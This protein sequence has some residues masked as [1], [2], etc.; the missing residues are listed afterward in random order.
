MVV[1]VSPNAVRNSELYK[2][3]KDGV[4]KPGQAC[5]AKLPSGNEVKVIYIKDDGVLKAAEKNAQFGKYGMHYDPE[6]E[7]YLDKSI[8]NSKGNLII[9]RHNIVDGKSQLKE[10]VEYCPR[11]KVSQVYCK[12]GSK[13]GHVWTDGRHDI[14]WGFDGLVSTPESVAT[15][16]HRPPYRNE[17]SV[18]AF[19]AARDYIRGV[20]SLDAYKEAM[21][22]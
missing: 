21:A 10:I 17:Y 14:C 8:M 4:I 6:P 15:C 9:A 19:R 3:V 2:L 18:D 7:E 11:G 12:D 16:I 1:K 5:K 22:K 20:G 13:G